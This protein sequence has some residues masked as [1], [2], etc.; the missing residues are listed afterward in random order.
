MHRGNNP[1]PRTHL[2]TGIM[3]TTAR[4]QQKWESGTHPNPEGGT[5]RRWCHGRCQHCDAITNT[6]KAAKSHLE[7][8]VVSLR[9]RE[10]TND[11]ETN[12]RPPTTRDRQRTSTSN[13]TIAAAGAHHH[14]QTHTRNK[15]RDN[16]GRRVVSASQRI[17]G[18]FCRHG[19]R[20]GNS[21]PRR[22]RSCTPRPLHQRPTGS[23]EGPQL[24]QSIM[25]RPTA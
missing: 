18:T 8:L 7:V 14:Q 10:G 15:G 13:T 24:R 19:F 11:L 9:L 5:R 12:P 23:D 1:S 4:H 17:N 3:Q 6:T 22:S 20:I 25:V 2:N 21:S 16:R